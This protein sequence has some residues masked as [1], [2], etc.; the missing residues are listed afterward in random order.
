M[1]ESSELI[2]ES[3]YTK[4]FVEAFTRRIIGIT[5]IYALSELPMTINLLL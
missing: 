3:R 2:R 4:V 5:T 1:M